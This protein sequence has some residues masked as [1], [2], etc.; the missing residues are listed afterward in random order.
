MRKSTLSDG[1][2]KYL[3]LEV[4]EGV[5]DTS[6]DI[7]GLGISVLELAVDIELPSHGRLWQQLRY[8]VLPIS[9]YDSKSDFFNEALRFLCF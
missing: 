3:A 6:C 5:Y 2:A 4:L 9:F 1:D 8:G 7:F